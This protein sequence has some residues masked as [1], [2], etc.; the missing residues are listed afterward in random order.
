[1]YEQ[2][3]QSFATRY[4]W[5]FFLIQPEP[6]PETLLG[7]NPRFYLDVHLKRQNKTQGAVTD[8]RS[9]MEEY[10]RCYTAPGAIHATCEDYRAAASIDIEQIKADGGR[11]S[12]VPLLAL[13]GAKGV[14][15]DLFDVL[16]LWREKVETVSGYTL[17][18]GHFLPEEDPEGVIRA[19]REF[20]CTNVT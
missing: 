20:F 13:W 11:K 17:P 6:I 1:M 12:K 5:W 2:T 8:D 3:T 19:V 15:G 16:G 18:C 9:I 4:F 7:A 14:V 10:A